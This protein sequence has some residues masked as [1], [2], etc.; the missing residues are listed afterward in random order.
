MPG[1][2]VRFAAAPTFYPTSSSTSTSSTQ[3]PHRRVPRY[4]TGYNHKPHPPIPTYSSR[5]SRIHNLLAYSNHPTLHFDVS[6]PLNAIAF[7]SSRPST[8]SLSES[9]IDPPVA[10]MTLSIPHI[11]WPVIVTPSNGVFIMVAD[12]LNAIY[13]TLRSPITK[14]EYR[15]IRSPSDLKRVN[16]AYE[17][18]H[19]RIRDDYAAYRE[20]QGG[21]RR[22]DFLAGHTRFLGVSSTGRNFILNLS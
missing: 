15:A 2:H 7:S 19:E 8:R 17:R 4:T 14:E 1:K 10:S 9:A 3:E 5:T 22:V 13:S 20:R 6:L 11:T 16:A 21:V 12:V 18:R